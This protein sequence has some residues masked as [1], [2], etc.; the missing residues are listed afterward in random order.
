MTKNL[1][2]WAPHL[3][4]LVATF[5][6]VLT[7]QNC[8]RVDLVESY[9]VESLNAEGE[10]E[11]CLLPEETLKSVIISNLSIAFEQNG[12]S[13]DSD[14]DGISDRREVQLGL[15]PYNPRT[16]G[17]L[18]RL[19]LNFS[20]NGN[21]GNMCNSS[22]DIWA[23]NAFGLNA[24][25]INRIL[26]SFSVDTQWKGVDSDLD[27]I[28]DVLELLRGTQP[29]AAD[30]LAD[31]DNDQILNSR[32]YELGTNPRWA[33]A[34][35]NY[36]PLYSISSAKVTHAACPGELWKI[37]IHH[38]TLVTPREVLNI[39]ETSFFYRN[40]TQNKILV[41]IQTHLGSTPKLYVAESL[42]SFEEP[43]MLLKQEDF[44]IYPRSP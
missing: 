9:S 6:I 37:K 43:T 17:L 4:F 14:Q 7:Y 42:L 32:E 5:G 38:I 31:Y 28:P 10:I 29:I 20:P 39:P 34:A 3:S 1:V 8:A 36:S 35:I 13:L 44:V 2:R 30:T 21:C 15:N 41:S 24:C 25:D 23:E 27:G 33:N 18:D 12:I 11:L 40:P 19:C 16:Y 26:G 22:E